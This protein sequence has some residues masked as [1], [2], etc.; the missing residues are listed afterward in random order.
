MSSSIIVKFYFCYFVTVCFLA[1]QN[2][3]GELLN[4]PRFHFRDEAGRLGLVAELR[5]FE[6]ERKQGA[7]V[8]AAEMGLEVKKTLPNFGKAEL[9]YFD[10]GK[11]VYYRTRNVNAAISSGADLVRSNFGY[12]GSGLSVGVW[13]GGLVLGSHQEFGG[14][15]RLLNSAEAD[16]HAT[17]VAGTIGAAGVTSSAKGMAPNIG[18]DSYDWNSDLS[19]MAERAATAPN[20]TDRLYVS[21]HSYGPASGW[22]WD[23][24]QWTWWGDGTTSGAIEFSYGRYYWS[25]Q[26]IDQLAYNAPYY[27]IFWSAGNDRSDNPSAGNAVYLSPSATSTVSYDPTIHPPGDGIYRGGYEC[28]SDEAVGKNVLT[29]GAVADAVSGGLRDPSVASMSGFSSWG[30]TDDGRIKPDL[31]AN[32]VS[33]TSPISNSNTSYGVSSGTSMASPSAAGSAALLIEHYR[34]L[35]PNNDMLA[36]TLK[37]LLIHTADDL[38]NPGPDYRNGWGLVNVDKAADLLSAHASEPVRGHLFEGAVT[39]SQFSYSRDFNWDGQSAI[40]ATLCWTDPAGAAIS[41]A[42]SRS[43]NLVN[44]LNLRVISPA[45]TIHYPF[46]MPFVGNWSQSSMNTAA[47]T[48]VNTVDN[49]EQ[50][51]IGNPGEVGVYRIEVDYDGGLTNGR[52]FFSLVLSGVSTDPVPLSLSSV[53]PTQVLQEDVQI[54]IAGTGILPGAE[55]KL[56]RAGYSDILATNVAIVQ[57]GLSCQVNLSG[58]SPGLWDVVVVNPGDVEASIVGGLRVMEPF[59]TE[60]FDGQ[61]SGWISNA[62]NGS[63]SWGLS[64]SASHTPTSSYFISGP[65][66]VTTTYLESPVI[67]IP[68][69][70]SELR[71]SFWHQ[72]QTE[73]AKDGGRLEFSVNEGPWEAVGGGGT[74]FRAGGYNSLIEASGGPNSR[75]DFSGLG[76][77]SGSNGGFSEV[78]VGLDD[79]VRFAGSSLRFRWGFATDRRRSSTGWY[80]DTFRVAGVLPDMVTYQGWQGENFSADEIGDLTAIEEGDP[81]GDGLV[82]FA[83]FA[84]GTDPKDGAG[85]PIETTIAGTDL[86]M[87]FSRPVG[88]PVNYEAQMSDTLGGWTPLLLESVE[89]VDGVEMMRATAPLNSGDQRCFVR[90]RMTAQ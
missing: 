24:S 49:V 18:I 39:T 23:G 82:N 4:D 86:V 76:A 40:I 83:E 34:S 20:Q 84:L 62:T 16:S 65:A 53:N 67:Q 54:E 15:V 5:K 13:D 2:R 48:G 27:L 73:S 85:S 36:S 22:N 32:G 25:S 60:D 68:I 63:N 87:T 70:A 1:G 44:D 78:V 89:V 45:G 52:Q 51:L 55:V 80:V 6:N 11:P 90:L 12:V 50:I 17:H 10:G 72:F 69:E 8:K 19:E 58:V 43:P 31:V 29:I 38:G 14:R 7:L 28:L 47:V 35:F 33:V 88:L 37:G 42:D 30:P 74:V 75:S 56:V 77:W 3:L 59:F 21:N 81:D 79:P 26:Q 46:V 41:S 66:A 61:I 64:Q 71:V 9:M 57:G